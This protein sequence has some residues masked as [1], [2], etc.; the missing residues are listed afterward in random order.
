MKRFISTVDLP[1][2][3]WL[4]IRKTGITGTDAGAVV[5][6]N[7][8]ISAFQVYHDKITEEI[9][10][11]DSEA[12]RQGRDMEEYVARRFMEQTG[13]KV[14]RANA[15]YQCDY[16]PFMLADFDRLIAGERAG[17]ECKT[18]SPYSAD[19]WKDGAIPMHYQ[20]QV[21]HYLAVSGYDRW[22][23]A[24]LVFGR[25]FIVRVIERDEELISYLVKIESR[26]WNE[27]VLARV[28]PDPDGTKNCSELI[29]K[30]Y[31]RS[32]AKKTVELLGCADILNRREELS[33]LITKLETERNTIDQK[34]KLQ[35]EDA[36]NGIADGYRVSWTAVT[37][38]RLD[39]TRLRKEKPD[40][41]EEYLKTSTSRRFSVNPAA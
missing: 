30:Q 21:Q 16:Y 13:K 24:A 12:M 32:D 7:P 25:D 4:R 10:E 26:F 39:T 2:D 15:V 5:G 35:M 40:I 29:A 38:S 14:H 37:S 27:N 8:Y 18:V 36:E 23:I 34:I 9:E 19:K 3:Q 28:M 33:Q 6:L 1:K 11:S 17:L 20:M 31:Y 41:Y 22:Y